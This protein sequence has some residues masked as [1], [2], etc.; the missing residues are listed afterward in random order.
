MLWKR[1]EVRPGEKVVDSGEL[2]AAYQRG[3]RDERSRRKSHPLMMM[4]TIVAALV[5]GAILAIAAY[6]GS[7]TEAGQVVDENLAV[8]AQEARPA[9]LRA[10]EEG[11]QVLQEAGR[12]L[13]NPDAS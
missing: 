13:Q 5:G 10:A 4:L 7:F 1:V 2:R 12:D 3:V 11:G 9:A 6:Q 8:A